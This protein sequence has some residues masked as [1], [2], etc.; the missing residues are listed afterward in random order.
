[1]N[2]FSILFHTNKAS[3]KNNLSS[4]MPFYCLNQIHLSYLPVYYI[5]SAPNG[6]RDNLAILK[7]CLPKGIPIIVI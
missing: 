4:T 6:I 1:M 3:P 5:T 2:L 7:N